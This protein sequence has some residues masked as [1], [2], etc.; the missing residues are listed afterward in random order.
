MSA[1]PSVSS[2]ISGPVVRKC[3][4]EFAG[5]LNCCGIQCRFGSEA[6]ISSARAMAPFIPFAPSVRT[7]SAPYAFSIRRRSRLIVSGMART[8]G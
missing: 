2:Q 8:S 6:T 7:S 1:V 3:M 4:S 5:L